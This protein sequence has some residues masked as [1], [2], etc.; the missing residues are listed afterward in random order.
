MGRRGWIAAAAAAV[1]AFVGISGFAVDA[2]ALAVRP[3]AVTGSVTLQAV[4]NTD[5]KADLFLYDIQRF[6][7]G[8]LTTPSTFV[9]GTIHWHLP[10]RLNPN[11]CQVAV[12]TLPQGAWLGANAL[13]GNVAMG[14]DD[15]LDKA[16][17]MPP[18][19]AAFIIQPVGT[20]GTATF[21]FAFLDGQKPFDGNAASAS[22][23][24]EC[25]NHVHLFQQSRSTVGPVTD[26]PVSVIS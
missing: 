18:G 7:G 12:H 15:R 3:P 9:E 13:T 24:V 11:T 17:A 10:R 19:I 14:D 16:L 5:P 8:W 4:R 22:A 21:L 25:E 20:D 26:F 1:V 23:T 6:D 2:H